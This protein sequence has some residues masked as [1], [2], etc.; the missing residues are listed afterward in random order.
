MIFSLEALEAKHGDSLLL[1][2]GTAADP[3]L[4][5]I[6][7][8]PSGVFADTLRP[9]LDEIRAQRAPGGRLEIRMVMVSHVDDDHIHGILELTKSMLK[10]KAD[11]NPQAYRILTF[12]HN[13]FDD[14]VKKV[15]MAGLDDAKKTLKTV[16]VSGKVPMKLAGHIQPDAALVLASIDQG[17]SLRNNAIQ[18][19]IPLNEG[20]DL[21]V[22]PDKKAAKKNIGSGLTFTIIGPRQDQLDELQND[23]AKQIAA[24]KKKGTL[25]PAAMEAVAAEFVDK[26]VYNLSSIV[27]LAEAGGKTM[28]LTGDARGD[29]VMEGLEGAGLKQPGKQF[30]IDI[31]KMPHH[32]SVRNVADAF[33][34]EIVADHYII[35]ANGKYDNPD[36]ATLEALF[37]ARGNASYSLYMTNH[38]KPIDTFLAKKK[39]SK[40]KVIYAKKTGDITALRVDLGQAPPN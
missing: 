26:S 3:K 36:K 16:S 22:A 17:R 20:G 28:L 7:G 5:V 29:Y 40:V 34:E 12:W 30:K 14:L 39:P 8:G 33:F 1:H 27:V 15:K 6:D 21:L 24:M 9:R 13:S 11:G 37:K 2:Y 35:S 38:V 4:I 19:A 23:W 31:L 32:G 18:L 10:A 25:K